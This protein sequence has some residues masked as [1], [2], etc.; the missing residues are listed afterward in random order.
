MTRLRDNLKYKHAE[1]CKMRKYFLDHGIPG[2]LMRRAKHFLKLHHY[3]KERHVKEKDL[4]CFKHLPKCIRDDLREQSFLPWL[5]RHPFFRT[6]S[7][8]EPEAARQLCTT[9]V[10]EAYL[11]AGEEIFWGQAVNRMLFVVDGELFYLHA[12][13]REMPIRIAS[14]EWCCEECIWSVHAVLSGPLMAQIMG[15]E[16]LKLDPME[17]QDI[18]RLYPD[19][20]KFV[21]KYAELFITTFN[22]RSNDQTCGIDDLL[23]SDAAPLEEIV[24]TSLH[25]QLNLSNFVNYWSSYLPAHV[26][27]R[28]HRISGGLGS[29]SYARAA[30]YM[31][32]MSDTFLG[33]R[34]MTS[35]NSSS[36]SRDSCEAGATFN[37]VV[38]KA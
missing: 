17:V 38:P 18:A 2:E 30:S 12:E 11:M 20:V 16:V 14:G 26:A 23:F 1:D 27:P 28:S 37:G 36:S 34:S 10:E 13:D 5:I 24:E 32:T 6:W 8:L 9:G 15:C 19:T 7:S 33:E 31:R 4:E 3:M 25:Q 22:A 29:L 35:T 21:V